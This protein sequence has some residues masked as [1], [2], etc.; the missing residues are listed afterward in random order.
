M[1]NDKLYRKLRIFISCPSDVEPERTRLA[2]VIK[3]DLEWLADE[4]GVTLE[5]LDWPNVTPGA[6]RPEKVILDDI[7]PKSWDVFIGILWHRFGT[8][9]QKNITGSPRNYLSGTEEEFK[10]A[11]RLWKDHKRPRVMFYRCKRDVS[12][13]MIDTEQLKRVNIFFSEF[14]A[15]GKHPALYHEYKEQADF[16]R[17]VR[18]HLG[19]LLFKSRPRPKKTRSKL[20]VT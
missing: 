7:K 17:A 10:A 9:P 15:A 16:E 14:S 3:E 19:Q 18:K 6:G 5:F 4:L 12:P 2:T 13:D 11:Y 20:K 8:P 1:P